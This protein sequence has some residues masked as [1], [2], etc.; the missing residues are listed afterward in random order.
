[1]RIP[2]MLGCFSRCKIH[3]WNAVLFNL[4]LQCRLATQPLDAYIPFT[5]LSLAPSFVPT[6][7][8]RSGG[9]RLDSFSCWLLASFRLNIERLL[10]PNPVSC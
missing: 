4:G 2:L 8:L 9:S 7:S 1:M 3:K 5:A 6:H 10:R